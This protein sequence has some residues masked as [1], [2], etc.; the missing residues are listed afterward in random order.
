[1]HH[2]VSSQTSTGGTDFVPD[3]D[4]LNA[5]PI[6]IPPDIEHDSMKLKSSF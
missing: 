1:M 6:W 4:I 2:R 3:E 5:A